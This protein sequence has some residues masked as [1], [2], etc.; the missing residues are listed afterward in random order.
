MLD[1]LMSPVTPQRRNGPPRS[2]ARRI[3]PGAGAK[4]PV[5]PGRLG[6]ASRFDGRREHDHETGQTRVCG[7]R[8]LRVGE[9]RGVPI[10]AGA[11]GSRRGERLMAVV[12]TDPGSVACLTCLVGPPQSGVSE[13]ADDLGPDCEPVELAGAPGDG[14]AVGRGGV[15]RWIAARP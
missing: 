4:K 7:R 3:D 6:R 14:R 10:G 9:R 8:D 2:R 12:L 5:R 15:A 11:P 1:Y 13:V